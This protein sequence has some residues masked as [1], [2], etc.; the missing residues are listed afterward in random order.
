MGDRCVLNAIGI[1]RSA[2]YYTLILV[3]YLFIF[4]E[5]F[6]NIPLNFIKVTR[7]NK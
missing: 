1:A 4:T 7:M 3:I 2:L 5:I 6:L